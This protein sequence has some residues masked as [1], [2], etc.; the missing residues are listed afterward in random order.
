MGR[1]VE[2]HLYENELIVEKAH[3]DPWKLP[4]AWFFGILFCWLIF[5]LIGAIV[6]TIKYN[7]TELV[8]T[9]KRVIRKEG[10]FNTRSIDV[11]LDKVYNVFVNT[12]FWG[13]VFN[14]NMIYIKTEDGVIVDRIANADAFKS[15]I[16]GQM[17]YFH[18]SRLAMQANWTAH[19]MHTQGG[20]YANP[21]Q[22]VYGAPYAP[23]YA[24]APMGQQQSRSNRRRDKDEYDDYGYDL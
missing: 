21:G 14:T 22:Q 23:P 19:A 1:Y 6:K 7:C 13:K 5:P 2:R 8:L 20:Y 10:V 3:R 4:G 16:L 17:D 15:D 11:P 12:T 9:N 18:E 24:R